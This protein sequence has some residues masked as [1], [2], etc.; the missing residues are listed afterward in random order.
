[1]RHV[2]WRW[3]ALPGVVAHLARVGADLD[4]GLTVVWWLPDHLS[5][6]SEVD[7]LLAE[8]VAD[9]DRVLVPGAEREAWWATPSVTPR[10][11]LVASG[12]DGEVPDW[13]VPDWARD[14]LDLRGLFAELDLAPESQDPGP[15]APHVDSLPERIAE[16]VGDPPDLGDDPVAALAA[17]PALRGKVVVVRAWCEPDR[18][19]LRAVLGRLPAVGKE[20]GLGPAERPRLLVAARADDLPDVRG[21][22]DPVTTR[23]HWWWGVLGRLDTAVVVASVRPR[24]A[25]AGLTGLRELVA[26]EV[27][28]EVAGPDLGLAEHLASTWGGRMAELSD[29]VRAFAG[30]PT[31][32]WAEP[33][34]GRDRPP[35]ETRPAWNEGVADLWERQ[36]R[37][38]PAVLRDPP[39][40]TLV[41]R[42][43][44]RALVPVIDEERAALEGVFRARASMAVLAEVVQQ[45]DRGARRALTRATLELGP[46]CWA[47]ET[48]RVRLS[49]WDRERL[50]RLRDARNALAHLRPLND[51][52]L[53]H[54]AAVVR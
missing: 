42:G 24:A 23:E 49:S 19:G 13:D 2:P 34:R 8:V 18:D 5:R 15:F 47:V 54:L 25:G 44:H 22:I 50:F 30:E 39:L 40:E 10:P 3:D 48:S 53:D 45:R 28:T 37:V 11:A 16:A 31:A 20:H 43:Q 36:I 41:W 6:Q 14:G 1:M 4:A 52:E 26:R 33:G 29:A 12:Q 21:R 27:I 32:R 9:Q 35:E 17:W 7:D 51:D 38:S 46:M